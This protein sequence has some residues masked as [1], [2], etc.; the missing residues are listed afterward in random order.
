MLKQFKKFIALHSHVMSTSSNKELTSSYSKWILDLGVTHH[1]S[2]ILSQFISLG[3][4][5]SKSI[6][7]A[8]GDSMPLA[9]IGSV[10]ITS[11]SLSDVYYISSLTTNL[12]SVSKICDS[13]CDVNFQFSIVLYMIKKHT[14]CISSSTAPF[15]IVHSVVWGPSPVSTKGGSKYY[16]SFINDFTVGI[17]SLLDVV[18]I[19]AA[20][21]CVNAA[22]LELVLLRDFK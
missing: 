21:I 12:A 14:K 7:A 6:V 15:D 17:K 9:G 10:D 20:Y 2:H 19:T 3:L 8:N 4:N 5:S 1:M 13:G 22:Q 18:R 16:V 11:I